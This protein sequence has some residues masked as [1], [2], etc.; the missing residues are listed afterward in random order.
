MNDKLYLKCLRCGRKLKTIESQKTGYGKICEQKM[1]SD[2][3][4]K[5]F[6]Q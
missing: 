6:K 5:L 2:D 1:K 4:F 3:K